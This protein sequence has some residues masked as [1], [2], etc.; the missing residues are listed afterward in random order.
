VRIAPVPPGSGQSLDPAGA[1]RDLAAQLREAYLAD[2]ANAV[3][4]RE[5]R[6]TLL[7]L[8]PSR[9]TAVDAELAQLMGEIAGFSKPVRGRDWLDGG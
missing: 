1:L 2:P 9:D 7:A 3:L 8:I 4:A 6:A 5:Y